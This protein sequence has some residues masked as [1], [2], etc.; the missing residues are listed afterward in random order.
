MV[1]TRIS[2]HAATSLVMKKLP[3]PGTSTIEIFPL[4][5]S[6]LITI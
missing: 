4:M 3:L 2:W 1:V 5:V 6:E